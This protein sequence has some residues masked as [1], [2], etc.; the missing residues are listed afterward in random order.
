MAGTWY[1]VCKYYKP[2][3]YIKIDKSGD[4]WYT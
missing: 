1:M 4:A 3:L 2:F